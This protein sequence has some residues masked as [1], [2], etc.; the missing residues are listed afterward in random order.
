MARS[1]IAFV[2]GWT[3][4]DP[5]LAAAPSFVVRYRSS[6]NVYLDGGKGSGLFLGDHLVIAVETETVAEL[7]VVFLAESSASCRIVSEKRS[8]RGG[9]IATLVPRSEPAAASPPAPEVAATEPAEGPV[10]QVVRASPKPP[11]PF[12]R[13]R[14][15][16]ALGLYKV[17]DTGAGGF[18]FEQRLGRVDVTLSDIA[19]QP[20]SLNTRFR[21]RRDVR[22]VSLGSTRLDKRNDLYE[23]SLRYEPPSD[24]LAFEVGRLGSSRFSAIGYLDGGLLRVRLGSPIQIGGFFGRRADVEGLPVEGQGQK[25]GGFLRVSPRDPYSSSYDVMV[26]LVR[27]FA[28]ED[29]SREYVGVE[30]RLGSGAV[31]VFGRTEIDLNRGWRGELSAE[32]Y[33][34]SN[35][36]AAA[37]L[38]FSDSV[39]TVLSYDSRRSYRD[40]FTRDVPEQIFDDLLHQGYRASLYLGR[41]YGLNAA[42]GFG[43]RLE[44]GERPESYSYNASLRHGNVFGRSLSLGVDGS[45]FQNDLTDGYLVTAQAGKRFGRGHELDFSYGRSTYRVKATSEERVTEYLRCSGRV[46]L[47]RHL[48]LLTDLE[49]DRGD[50]LQGPRGYFEVGYQF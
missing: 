35:V 16:V 31:S 11:Q 6:T 46:D 22:A 17:R 14:G 45:G 37:N 1:L 25:Y 49:Y 29:I 33:Q 10:L 8:V 32:D 4:A 13:L 21:T 23:L 39:L 2:L 24:D 40:Y 30:A 36:S 34:F 28:Q 41:G 9:D 19:G 26:A 20:I 5:A 43:V 47:G 3:L 7:E 15:G 50:D 42:A 38:R 48:Y 44:E 12:A 18:D 27:E